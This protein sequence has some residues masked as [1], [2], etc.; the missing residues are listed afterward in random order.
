MGEGK[1][2]WKTDKERAE[3]TRKDK[4]RE[5]Q[6]TRNLHDLFWGRKPN[7]TPPISRR[8]R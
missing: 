8:S 7:E 5:K 4:E 1:M 3:Q 2:T 6:N